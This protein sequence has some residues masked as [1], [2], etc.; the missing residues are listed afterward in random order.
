MSNQKKE[1]KMPFVMSTKKLIL[2]GFIYVITSPIRLLGHLIVYLAKWL[3]LLG[4]LLSMRL[5]K[6]EIQMNKILLTE[7]DR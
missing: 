3:K 5:H 7:L 1:H 4:Y 6:V 2:W